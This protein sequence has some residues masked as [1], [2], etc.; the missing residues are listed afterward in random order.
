MLVFVQGGVYVGFLEAAAGLITHIGGD[1]W[2]MS[3]GTHALDVAETS[4]EGDATP[5]RMVPS[6]RV[7]FQLRGNNP[8]WHFRGSVRQTRESEK[9]LRTGRCCDERIR[10]PPCG[11]FRA[12]GSAF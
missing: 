11:V 1:V 10:A 3:R 12:V 5:L 6:Q 8:H 2:V 7:P 4:S 9:P